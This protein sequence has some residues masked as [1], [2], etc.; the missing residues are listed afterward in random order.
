MVVTIPKTGR[1]GS[2][3]STIRQSAEVMVL[4][5]RAASD[6]MLLKL[7]FRSRASYVAHRIEGVFRVPKEELVVPRITL[8]VISW[9]S[10]LRCL[11]SGTVSS[12]RY[13]WCREPKG[14]RGWPS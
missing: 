8:W 13:A 3:S 14:R 6:L 12:I 7:G 9:A 1:F 2:R 5:Y 10:I 11:S 4:P